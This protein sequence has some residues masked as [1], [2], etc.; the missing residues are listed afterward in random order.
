MDNEPKKSLAPKWN[1]TMAIVVWLLLTAVVLLIISDIYVVFSGRQGIYDEINSLP[2]SQAVMVLG[3]SVL[4]NGQMSDIFRDRATMALEVYNSGK[5][6]KILVSGD[7]QANDYDEVGTAK[8]FLLENGIPAEDIF[9]DYAGYDTY[10]SIYRAKYIFKVKTL[11][12]STQSFHLPRALYLARGMGI[13]AVGIT[14]DLR[15]YSL[16]MHNLLREN[17]ARIKAFYELITNEKS[18]VTGDPV[19]ITGDGR[20]SWD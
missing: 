2:E 11:I 17:A 13:E 15:E 1:K 19:P 12:I 4:R 14:A 5:A 10:D 3:S 20:N 9:L 16:G 8:K 6:R 18:K 7:Y